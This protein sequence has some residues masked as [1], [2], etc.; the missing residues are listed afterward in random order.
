MK[1]KKI[2]RNII[3]ILLMSVLPI[4]LIVNERIQ[5]STLYMIFAVAAMICF[6]IGFCAIFGGFDNVGKGTSRVIVA[7]KV[8]EKSELE[9][10]KYM[11]LWEQIK[12]L[13]ILNA[14]FIVFI[15]FVWVVG[16]VFMFEDPLNFF[17]TF[18]SSGKIR[19]IFLIGFA[20]AINIVYMIE[21]KFSKFLT[22][23][24]IIIS[25]AILV[26]IYFI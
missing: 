18:D 8:I 12:T 17:E 6:F 1:N 4:F 22:V 16:G 2:K 9:N 19:A 13:N 3:A 20:L 11:T 5:N 10:L 24:I 14:V 15:I 25:I 23:S 26:F 21:A 7:G